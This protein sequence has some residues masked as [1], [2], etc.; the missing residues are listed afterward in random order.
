MSR[1]GVEARY[2]CDSCGRDLTGVGF[3]VPCLC[4]NSYRRR[5][6]LDGA[7]FRRPD[8][9]DSP[10]W[11][12][13][14][15]WTVKYLQFTW[16]VTQLRR[17]YTPGSGAAASEVRT[18][19][20]HVFSSCSELAAWLGSGPE[21]VCVTPGDVTRLVAVEPLA[22]GLAFGPGPAPAGGHSRLLAASFGSQPRFWVQY[23]R[24]GRKAQRYDAL[25][26]A[27][28]CLRAWLAFFRDRPVVLPTWPS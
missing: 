24:P 11:D 7:V 2:L 22:I 17:L 20:E 12:P 13:F 23:E 18:V 25:D 5:V 26:L 27:E 14:K 10:P 15:D 16:N 8:S 28:R 6:D 1:A 19:A 4:G 9:A 3:A 21:P